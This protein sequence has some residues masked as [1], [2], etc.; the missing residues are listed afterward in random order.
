[1]R[2]EEAADLPGESRPSKSARKRSA[3]AVQDLGVELAALPDD[4]LARLDLP[5]TLHAAILELRRLSAHG[6]QLRQRQYIGKL[7]RRID[8]EPV[9]ARLADRK[10]RHDVE[11]RRFQQIERWRDRLMAEPQAALAELLQDHPQADRAALEEL[12]GRCATEL[13]ERRAPLAARELF[14]LLRRL[15]D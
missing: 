12:I 6:A 5:E 13:R 1:M 7:M 9:I 10:R 11:V 15:L 8:P 4:E 2:D 3:T 14:A